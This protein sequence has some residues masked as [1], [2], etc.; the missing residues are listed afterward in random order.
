MSKLTD[1][2]EVTT[3]ADGD[4]AMAVDVSNTSMDATGTNSKV[5]L[6]NVYAYI[7]T[8]TD[9]LYAAVLGVDDNYVTDAE[10]TAIASIVTKV[11]TPVNNQVG[12]WT[13]DGTLEGDVD[14]TFDGTRASVAELTV[15]NQGTEDTGININGVTYESTFKVSDID[16]TNYA[17]NILHRHSTTLEPLVLF[18]RSNSNTTSHTAV[19]TGQNIGCIYGSGTA[20]NNYK[21]FGT[22]CIAVDSGTI[23]ETSAPG[24]IVFYTTPDGSISPA[25]VLTLGQD[26]SATF[27][28]NI[29]NGTSLSLSTGTIELGH[30]TDTTIAR[31]SAGV[32]SIEGNNI[33]VN[34]SSP[35]LATVTTTGNIELGNASDTTLSRSAAGILAVEGVV[36]PSISSTNTIT[37]K[38]NQPRVYSAANNASLT[39]EIDTYDIF[40]LTAMSAATTINN[41]SS[42]TP[43]D[44]ELMEIRFLDNGTAR[45]LTWGTKYVAKAGVALPTTTVLSKN[46][47]V[48]FEYNSN[49]TEWNLLSSGQQA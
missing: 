6:S 23:S 36:I 33:V 18:A 30:A 47:V 45:A 15:G 5:T 8:K 25:T 32:A 9:L 7:K 38:R 10:K 39:P 14:F 37:N 44:G 12:I 48:L 27:T 4:L 29:S 41:P 1:L 31:V 13:G 35:T 28:G 49:L 46:L 42:T 43:A 34:T 22:M 40:H 26:K 21:L 24:K 2:T 17:Q 16:G 19:T 3:L 11:G 20:G